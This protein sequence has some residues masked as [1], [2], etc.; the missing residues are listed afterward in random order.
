MIRN[1]KNIEP[2]N[3]NYSIDIYLF[4]YSEKVSKYLNDLKADDY[5]IWASAAL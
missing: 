1:I 5:S 3:T 2:I 4:K